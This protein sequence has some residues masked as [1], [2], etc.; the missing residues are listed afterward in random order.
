MR[1]QIKTNQ[2]K[3]YQYE[4]EMNPKVVLERIDHEFSNHFL[5]DSAKD[6]KTKE[7]MDTDQILAIKEEPID[8]DFQMDTDSWTGENIFVSDGFF[9]TETEVKE[10]KKEKVKVELKEEETKP[11]RIRPRLRA[12][13][14]RAKRTDIAT[15]VRSKVFKKPYTCPYCEEYITDNLNGHVR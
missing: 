7:A 2:S 15:H 8:D 14:D 11:K 1:E 5:L 3:I 13:K 10:E 9:P 12:R 4:A 6:E